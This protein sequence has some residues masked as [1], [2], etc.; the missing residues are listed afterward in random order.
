MLIVEDSEVTRGLL[1]QYFAH[2]GYHVL[3]A[4]DPD[5]AWEHLT[6]SH[7]DLVILDINLTYDDSGLDFLARMRVDL[8][9]AATAVVVVTAMTQL[10]PD[11]Q[12]VIDRCGAEVLYKSTGYV[13]AID[14]ILE[15]LMRRE[16]R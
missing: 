8:R 12:A 2:Y 11:Q 7:V 1:D 4:A 3:Q 14:S 5:G 16:P 10:S 9:F 15:R 13:S 6:A